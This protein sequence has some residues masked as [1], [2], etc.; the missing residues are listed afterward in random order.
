MDASN[1]GAAH[2]EPC[3]HAPQT[4][5]PAAMIFSRRFDVFM[6]SVCNRF[7]ID[8]GQRAVNGGTRGGFDAQRPWTATSA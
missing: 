7:S 3:S 8:P 2:N 4:H 5:T 6:I 1:A